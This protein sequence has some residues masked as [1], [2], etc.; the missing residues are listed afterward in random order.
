MRTK[1]T[2]YVNRKDV[3]YPGC[4]VLGPDVELKIFNTSAL[5]LDFASVSSFLK[6]QM[7]VSFDCNLQYFIRQES[8]GELH[9]MFDMDFEPV[10]KQLAVSTLKAT[11][12]KFTLENIRLNRSYVENTLHKDLQ[13][14]L[15]GDCCPDCCDDA[16]QN[17]PTCVSGCN[18][19]RSSCYPG[20]YVDIRYFN[21]GGII[22]PSQVTSILLTTAL[23]YV[24]ADT[25]HFKQT[26]ALEE[27]ETKRQVAHLINEAAEIKN[28]ADVKADYIM[29]IANA[30]AY[31]DK[32]LV[33]MQGLRNMCSALGLT[34]AQ[35]KLSVYMLKTLKKKHVSLSPGWKNA[36][37]Y[38]NQALGGL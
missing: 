4:H 25:E 34:D 36:S 7:E 33:D 24:K 15:G 22:L 6:D 31:A 19:D 14:K 11:T 37:T 32:S 2:G 38:T 16:C 35:Q 9:E 23:L 29:K 27:K 20:Y 30:K 13:Q 10:M 21:F 28:G 8:V 26:H 18:S 3:V 5:T 12:T 1:S 17:H